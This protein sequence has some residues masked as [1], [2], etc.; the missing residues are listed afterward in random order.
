MRDIIFALA[1]A[2]IALSIVAYELAALTLPGLHTISFYAHQQV[3]VRVTLTVAL[4][5][6][7]PLFWIHASRDIPR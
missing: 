2:V 3:W 4:L 5:S 7:A 1:A 6:L